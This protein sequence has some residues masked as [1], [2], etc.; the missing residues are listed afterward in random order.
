MSGAATGW[1]GQHGPHPDDLDRG[2]V[3]YGNRARGLRMV[4]LAV[5]DAANIE[6]K[7]A[8]PGIGNVARFSLYSSGGARRLLEELESEGWLVVTE[9]GGGR[10]K[11]TVYDLAMTEARNPVLERRARGAVNT[12]TSE[13][14]AVPETRASPPQTRACQPETRAPGCAPNGV[15]TETPTVEPPPPAKADAAASQGRDIATRVWE[16]SGDTKPATPFIAVTKIAAALVKAGHSPD[17]IVAAMG[18]V[19]T[20]S[21]RW[22]EAELNRRRPRARA[23]TAVT[24][25]R[26][27][28]SGRVVL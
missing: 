13:R 7:H 9:Q 3:K 1:V 16:A 25:D 15:P 8:H 27:A 6:G 12:G 22:V 5:A 14:T 2:G 19:P 23:T 10:G 4:L 28:P 20:I 17:D 11:A 24:Q 18:T 21:T 26:A